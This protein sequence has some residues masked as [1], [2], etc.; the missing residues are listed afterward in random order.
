MLVVL[1]LPGPTKRK[2]RHG[3]SRKRENTDDW[4]WKSSGERMES[5][6]QQ[7]EDSSRSAS[8][9]RDP[10]RYRDRYR[11]RYRDRYRSVGTYLGTRP[12]RG[13]VRNGASK[14]CTAR[15]CCYAT[16]WPP[17]CYRRCLRAV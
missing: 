16:P 15:A 3:I 12:D 11:H 2:T 1:F 7:Q 6:M 8:K 17:C 13:A 4:A 14:P 5:S 9:S 10:Y